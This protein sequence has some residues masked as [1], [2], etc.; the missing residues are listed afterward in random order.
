MAKAN[1]TLRQRLRDAAAETMLDAAE[2]AMIDKGYE[3]ATMHEIAAAAGC[4]TGT[5]YL[6]FKNKEVLLEAIIARHANAL[7]SA[8][9]AEMDKTANPLEKVRL[10][11]AYHL[12]YL[13]T[14]KGF[15]Q[16]FLTAIPLRHRALQSQLSPRVRALHDQY[17]QMELAALQEAQRKNLIRGDMPA[18]LLQEFMEAAGIAIVERFMFAK[19]KPSVEKQM[20]ILWGLI[21]GGI[22]AG[23]RDE[24]S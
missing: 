8:A 15:F 22:G 21:A 17:N 7:F 18:E 19:A 14:H 6:Y 12:R 3:R 16:L 24:R 4:A 9:L 2:K 23:S 1:S 5:F 13:N 10:G 11:V 20:K